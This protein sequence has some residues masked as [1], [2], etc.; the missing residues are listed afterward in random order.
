MV[1]FIHFGRFTLWRHIDHCSGKVS[2]RSF[3]EWGIVNAAP[4]F[5]HGHS[6]Y[7]F[8]LLSYSSTPPEALATQLM[9]VARSALHHSVSLNMEQAVLKHTLLFTAVL[10]QNKPGSRNDAGEPL[11]Q[12]EYSSVVFSSCMHNLT[13]NITKFSA[14]PRADSLNFQLPAFGVKLAQLIAAEGRLHDSCLKTHYRLHDLFPLPTHQMALREWNCLWIKCRRWQ[15]LLLLLESNVCVWSIVLCSMGNIE[16][17]G[18]SAMC[19]GLC[20]QSI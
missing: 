12:N 14:V 16:K 13:W 15:I 17:A 19:H 1:L 10:L 9:L 8:L 20:H 2:R 11:W 3:G 7:F 6:L 18:M 5:L 4:V